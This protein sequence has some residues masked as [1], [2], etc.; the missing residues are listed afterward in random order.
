MSNACS[1]CKDLKVFDSSFYPELYEGLT[2]LMY[3]RWIDEPGS[4]RPTKVTQT[5]AFNDIVLQLRLDVSGLIL[6]EFIQRKQ[7]K[8][9]RNLKDYLMPSE[10][11]P[12]MG[13]SENYSCRHQAE[14]QSSHKYM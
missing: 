14:I 12:Q 11:I 1:E 4:S 6:R 3:Q 7:S 10:C 5:K 13:Y 2:D 9:I 8:F